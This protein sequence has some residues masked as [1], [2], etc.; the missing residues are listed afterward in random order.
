MT[1]L[2][3][4]FLTSIGELTTRFTT[5][6]SVKMPTGISASVMIIR[7]TSSATIV[8]MTAKIVDVTDALVRFAVMISLTLLESIAHLLGYCVTSEGARNCIILLYGSCDTRII[9]GD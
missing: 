7:P 5:S 9:R 4:V 6:F 1:V 3:G 2:I 8:S